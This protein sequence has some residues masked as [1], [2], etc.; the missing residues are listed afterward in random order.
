[1]GRKIKKK[2]IDSNLLETIYK[3]ESEWKQIHS[4]MEKS[5][6]PTQNG[7]L[8]EALAQAKYIFLLK[9]ARHRKL[10]ALR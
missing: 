4:I 1:M 9:E 2:E 8:H 10:S 3:L 5:I 7:Q 6:E